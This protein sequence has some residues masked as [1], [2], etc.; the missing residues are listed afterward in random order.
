MTNR[1]QAGLLHPIL[2]SFFFVPQSAVIYT[3]SAV[4]F[5]KFEQRPSTL[6]WPIG[7]G[8]RGDG[9]DVSPVELLADVAGPVRFNKDEDS[10][11]VD[12]EKRRLALQRTAYYGE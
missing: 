12:N 11:R 1:N 9:V 3:V 10:R 2:L 5:V 4:N 8:A 6:L 7:P